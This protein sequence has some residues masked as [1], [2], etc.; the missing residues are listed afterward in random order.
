MQYANLFL[1]GL[2]QA[3]ILFLVACG[4]QLI[5]GVQKVVN[6]ACGSFY[7]LGAFSPSRLLGFCINGKCR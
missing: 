6:L 5:F 4:L 3:A 1:A 7:A 2:F